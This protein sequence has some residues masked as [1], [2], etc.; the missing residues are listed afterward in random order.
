MTLERWSPFAEMRRME[1]SLNRLWKGNSLSTQEV[2]AWGIPLDVQVDGDNVVV[3][4]SIP[5]IDPEKID[6]TV[7]DQVLTIRAETESESEEKKDNYVLKERRLV[8]PGGAPAR[9]RRLG[10]G[11]DKLQGRRV[12]DRLPEGRGTESQ[13][14]DRQGQLTEDSF[15]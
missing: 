5:G 1:D 15:H 9:Q 13:E 12:E 4:A 11:H 10:K 2:E 7:E 14:A 3:S 6:V 8:L